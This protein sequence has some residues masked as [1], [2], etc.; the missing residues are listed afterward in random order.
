MPISF[1]YPYPTMF[2]EFDQQNNHLNFQF[3]R[4]I[5]HS[6]TIVKKQNSNFRWI[7]INYLYTFIYF[8][9]L[10]L[11]IIFNSFI[12]VP[13]LLIKK[14]S[15]TA[16]LDSNYIKV[17]VNIINSQTGCTWPELWAC[18]QIHLHYRRYLVGE[19][20]ASCFLWCDSYS[21]FVI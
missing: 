5:S 17:F 20:R 4:V 18:T 3:V 2:T 7:M 13:I 15:F 16:I 14:I 21:V 6:F 11:Y 9:L 8:T 19:D 12:F 1:S 10:I